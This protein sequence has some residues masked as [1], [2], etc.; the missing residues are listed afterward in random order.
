ML[1]VSS[2]NNFDV[3]ADQAGHNSGDMR[4]TSSM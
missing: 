3:L 4:G 1:A 2:R